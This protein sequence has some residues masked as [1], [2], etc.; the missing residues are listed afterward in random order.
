[1]KAERD[2]ALVIEAVLAHVP[3]DMTALRARLEKIREDAAYLPPEYKT[4]AWERMA[5]ALSGACN[6]PPLL[7]W[8]KCVSAIVMGRVGE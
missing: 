3:S 7:D 5:S 2:P 1:V 4:P 6:E 8:E